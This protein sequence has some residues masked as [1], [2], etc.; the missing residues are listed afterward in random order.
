M[1]ASKKGRGWPRSHRDAAACQEVYENREKLKK[2]SN[3]RNNICKTVAGLPNG[4]I[5][6]LYQHTLWFILTTVVCT[7]PILIYIT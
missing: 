4:T 6:L 2:V 3:N 1:L 7:R 5:N